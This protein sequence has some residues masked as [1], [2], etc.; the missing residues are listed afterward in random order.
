MFQKNRSQLELRNLWELRKC[1]DGILLDTITPPIRLGTDHISSIMEDVNGYLWV[2]TFDK[3]VFCFKDGKIIYHL[4]IMQ[5]QSII[6]DHENNI[7]ISSMKDGVYK[8]SPYI[9]QHVHYKS[10]NF[11]NSPILGLNHHISNGIWCTNGKTVYLL[12]NNHLFPSD[13]Q[14]GKSSFN[15]ILQVNDSILL[16]GEI[17]QRQFALE[18]IRQNSSAK[19]IYFNKVTNSAI[20]LKK[21]KWGIHFSPVIELL[22]IS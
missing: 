14:N 7:W 17:S 4:D 21:F 16:V 9:N 18:G 3:G 13:F 8:V 2:S 1:N 11:Q 20:P 15:Q 6:Q 10:D 19:M 5:G 12:Q 22:I